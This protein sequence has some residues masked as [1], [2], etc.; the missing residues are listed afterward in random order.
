MKKATANEEQ[1]LEDE[2]EFSCVLIAIPFNKISAHWVIICG[3]GGEVCMQYA[4]DLFCLQTF[5][6]FYSQSAQIK[7]IVV[8]YAIHRYVDW[9]VGGGRGDLFTFNSW[10][11]EFEFFSLSEY[12]GFQLKIQWSRGLCI[13]HFWNILYNKGIYQVYFIFYTFLFHF[14]LWTTDTSGLSVGT[15]NINN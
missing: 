1:N 13:T 4:P 15:A 10:L 8:N 11:N 14:L 6:T 2:R 3:G 5:S 12:N 9:G 7:H